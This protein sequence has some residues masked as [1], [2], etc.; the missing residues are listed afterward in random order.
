MEVETLIKSCLRAW[1]ALAENRGTFMEQWQEQI[2]SENLRDG[3]WAEKF[4]KY[5]DGALPLTE[6]D[7]DF[8]LKTLES[9]QSF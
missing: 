2:Q 3:Y 4:I 6:V 9:H 5:T 7:T 1:N 8:T